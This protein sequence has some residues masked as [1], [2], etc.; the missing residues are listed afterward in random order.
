[1]RPGILTPIFH[2]LIS[3]L[4]TLCRHTQ[5][6][7]ASL[8]PLRQGYYIGK[9]LMQIKHIGCV[10]PTCSTIAYLSVHSVLNSRFL[11]STFSFFCRV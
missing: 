10:L 6:G 8:D 7:N 9:R 2:C 4:G 1:M 3:G 11:E 5:S